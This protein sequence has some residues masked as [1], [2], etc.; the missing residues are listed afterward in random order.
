MTSAAAPGRS[1]TARVPAKINLELLVGP[2]RDDG[3]HHLST[4]FQAVSV[5]DDVTVEPAD[6]WGITVTGP[7]ADL[8]PVDG[9]NLALRA[10]RALA[11][12]AGVAEPVHITIDKDIPVAGR[13]GRRVG[14]RGGRAGGLRR[15]VGRWPRRAASWRA[16]PPTSGRTSPSACTAAR[17]SAP[18]AGTSWPPS[19]DAG[20]TTGSSP[21]ATSG[22][23]RRRSTPSATGSGAR[24]RC[25]SPR[26]PRR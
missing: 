19:S 14:G 15:A 11:D 17:R 9:S 4:V 3:Y 26:R 13:H 5:Y 7:Y 23:P 20:A 8:V 25:P 2:R 22:S 24:R 6:D 12:V 16:W 18:A 10:A 21:S 1:V